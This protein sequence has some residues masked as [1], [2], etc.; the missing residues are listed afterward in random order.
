MIGSAFGETMNL[1]WGPGVVFLLVL[2][3]LI[4]RVIR[5][6]RTESQLEEERLREWM[7]AEVAQLQSSKAEPRLMRVPPAAEREKTLASAREAA[8]PSLPPA[9]P[10]APP[11]LEGTLAQ[12]PPI[13][14][15]DDMNGVT[16]SELDVIRPLFRADGAIQRRVLWVRSTGSHIAFCER[17]DPTPP[18][19][20]VREVITIVKIVGGKVVGKWQFG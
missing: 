2:V 4:R 16:A 13:V 20:L 9:D 5:A 15:P 19:T 18:S 7:K 14:V 8:A 10:V 3:W 12:G 11:P 6:A 1:L 17:R